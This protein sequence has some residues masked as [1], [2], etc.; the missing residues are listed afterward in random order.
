MP[1]YI[2]EGDLS[3]FFSQVSDYTDRSPF[4]KRQVSEHLRARFDAGYAAMVVRSE[5]DSNEVL[6]YQSLIPSI[7]G[8]MMESIL[9]RTALGTGLIRPGEFRIVETATAYTRDEYRGQGINK[10]LKTAMN[11]RFDPGSALRIGHAWNPISIMVNTES[12]GLNIIS[13]DEVPFLTE[14]TWFAP[15]IIRGT[16]GEL[17]KLG[18]KTIDLGHKEWASEDGINEVRELVEE[19]KDARSK[20]ER[21]ELGEE[22][23]PPVLLVSDVEKAKQLDRTLSVIVGA[24][25]PALRDHYIE[26]MYRNHLDECRYFSSRYREGGIDIITMVGMLKNITVDFEQRLAEQNGIKPL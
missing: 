26:Y 20:G 4:L 10:E 14:M 25:D 7:N 11:Q 3:D 22:A 17:L 24:I 21:V 6:G 1:A 16:S 12:N 2:T 15:Y 19:I 13:T 18:E 23:C 9:D 8:F 5:K